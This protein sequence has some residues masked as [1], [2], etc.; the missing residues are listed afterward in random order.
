MAPESTALTTKVESRSPYQLD[1]AQVTIASA[2]PSKIKLIMN[3]HYEHPA[4][5]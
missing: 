1:Q 4:H 5:F 2:V 3:R